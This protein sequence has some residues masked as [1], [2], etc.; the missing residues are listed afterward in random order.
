MESK[1][2]IIRR[3]ARAINHPILFARWFRGRLRHYLPLPLWPLWPL[4]VIFERGWLENAFV[5]L[6]VSR[7]SQSVSDREVV[8]RTLLKLISPDARVL[9]IGTYFGEG[10]TKVFIDELSNQASFF[11]M[12]KW[13]EYISATDKAKGRFFRVM[14]GMSYFAA[15][16]TLRMI[17]EEER[18]KDSPSITMIRRSSDD[19]FVADNF[20][21]LVFIDGSHYYENVRRDIEFA[22][23][24]LKPG[25]IICGDD[26]EILPSADLAAVAK[27]HLDQ[28]YISDPDGVYFHPGVALAVYELLGTVEM[29]AGTWWKVTTK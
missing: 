16:N 1:V 5:A 25:G 18:I 19:L 23:R 17:R 12:D 13:S 22:L 29:K 11:V 14:D 27:Q 28:D 4:R 7:K 8:L 3:L 20:F 2:S 6:F 9:E 24:I 21:D 26:L 15:T 10:T